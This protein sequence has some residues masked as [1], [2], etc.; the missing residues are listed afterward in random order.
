MICIFYFGYGP[1]ELAHLY[2]E[3]FVNFDVT[4]KTFYPHT[5][6]IQ[7]SLIRRLRQISILVLVYSSAN[8]KQNLNMLC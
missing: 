4:N 6:Y 8:E 2:G 1:L 7:F 3:K 5:T